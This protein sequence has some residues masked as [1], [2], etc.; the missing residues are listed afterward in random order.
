ML[1]KRPANWPNDANFT[2]LFNEALEEALATGGSSDEFAERYHSKKTALQLKRGRIVVGGCSQ[3]NR[4]RLHALN[5]AMLSVATVNWEIFLRSHLDIMNDRFQRVSDGSYAWAARKTYIRE[6]EV[7]D[8]DILN[9]LLGISLRIENPSINHYY[10]SIRRIS[11]ALAETSQKEIIEAKMLQMISGEGLD[12]FNR[13]LIYYLFLNYN[14]CLEDKGKQAANQSK[15]AE[16]VN[17]LPAYL[18]AKITVSK[19]P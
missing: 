5:I 7:L 12:D 18:A 9:L 14:Y 4:P 6:L 3:D 11:R 13:V 15:L 8:I 2:T 19:T 10:G 17:T 1:S 16:A